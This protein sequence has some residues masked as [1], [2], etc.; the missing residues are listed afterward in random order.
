MLMFWERHKALSNPKEA[1]LETFDGVNC[2]MKPKTYFTALW[3][4][5]IDDNGSTLQEM[6]QLATRFKQVNM[7]LFAWEER[8]YT[9]RVPRDVP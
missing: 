2:S 9:L 7:K 5:K 3:C 4:L 8:W 1:F 6:V